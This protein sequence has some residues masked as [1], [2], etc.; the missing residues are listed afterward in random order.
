MFNSCPVSFTSNS[1]LFTPRTPQQQN[2]YTSLW[3]YSHSPSPVQKHDGA[4]YTYQ[5]HEPAI[6]YP[7]RLNMTLLPRL[8]QSIE[9]K[10]HLNMSSSPRIHATA[11]AIPL[12]NGTNFFSSTL[13]ATTS[14][15]SS[16][17]LKHYDAKL[18]LQARTPRIHGQ[19]HYKTQ[20]TSASS[21]FHNDNRA[22]SQTKEDAA[23]LNSV[24][25]PRVSKPSHD[26]NKYHVLKK[27][28]RPCHSDHYNN[29]YVLSGI[30]PGFLY[31]SS[32][33]HVNKYAQQ[34]A[35]V[36]AHTGTKIGNILNVSNDN[37]I[38]VSRPRG[39]K[40]VYARIPVDDS[41]HENIAQYFM[42][43]I[44]F[45]EQVRAR[46]EAIVVHCVM[47]ISRSVTIVLAYLMYRYRICYEKAYELVRIAR[48]IARPNPGFEMQLLSF[49]HQLGILQE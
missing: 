36:D 39:F 9:S 29:P 31:L 19:N 20:Q 14:H 41:P 48:P 1:T 17:P 22:Y 32:G 42:S 13:H 45:I 8:K 4:E 16:I 15:A 44:S 40:G 11:N 26:A 24:Y 37:D 28:P 49:Q 12:D 7:G 47:G 43:A 27:M 3:N 2:K 34:N 33:A 18:L 30:I 25:S 35:L 21:L 46:N 23:L 38:G 5:S 6:H 10:Q